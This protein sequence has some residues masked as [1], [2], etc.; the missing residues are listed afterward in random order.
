MKHEKKVFLRWSK[1]SQEKKFVAFEKRHATA[2][3]QNVY[4]RDCFSR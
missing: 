1:Q 3:K 4:K 2:Y